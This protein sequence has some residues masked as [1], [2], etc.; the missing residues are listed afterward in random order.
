MS[1]YVP[2]ASDLVWL[3]FNPQAGHEQAGHR[4]A[5]VLSHKDYNRKTGL[6]I[7]CPITSKTKGYPFE[8]QVNGQKINGAVL[9]DQVKS[10]DWKVR[11]AKF[12]ER[13]DSVVFDEVLGKLHAIIG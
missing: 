12:I 6:A 11:K 3:E 4:P 7:L 8:V 2:A 5:I 10:F 9:A 1:K 13:A